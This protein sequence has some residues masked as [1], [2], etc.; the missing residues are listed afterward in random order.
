VPSKTHQ[1]RFAGFTLT[2]AAIVLGIVGLIL[3][4]VW[5]AVAAIYTNMRVS[6]TSSQLLQIV[7]NVRKLYA[8]Q[9]YIEAAADQLSLAALG[10]IPRGMIDNPTAPLH[11]RDEW[12]GEVLFAKQDVLVPGDGFTISMD[13]IPREGCSQLVFRST[14]AGHDVGLV[15]VAVGASAPILS[16]AMPIGIADANLACAGGVNNVVFT[17]L[18]RS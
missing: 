16:A 17:F 10:A 9:Q 2:E 12:G 11:V 6:T 8:H 5:V 1:S 15:S 7:T 18:L 3:V 14:S 4:S 13:N